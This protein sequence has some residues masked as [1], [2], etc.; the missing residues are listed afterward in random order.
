MGIRLTLPRSGSLDGS[1]G[2]W[3]QVSESGGSSTG[4]EVGIVTAWEPSQSEFSLS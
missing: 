2:A 4:V 3:N 1:R